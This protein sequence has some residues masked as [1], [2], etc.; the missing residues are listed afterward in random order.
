MA[1][2]GRQALAQSQA[3]YRAE[4]QRLV[5]IW[6]SVS[7]EYRHED[8]MRVRALPQDTMR[9]GVVSVLVDSSLQTLARASATEASAALRRRFG[10]SAMLVGSHLFTLT[11]PRRRDLDSSIV[12]LGEIDT[13][14]RVVATT[15]MRGTDQLVGTSMAQRGSQVLTARLGPQFR[16]WLNGPLPVDTAILADWVGARIDVVTSPYQAAGECYR[17]DVAA[18]K[19][20]LG[21]GDETDPMRSWFTASE[22]RDLVERDGWALR[23]GQETEYTQCV[24]HQIDSACVLLAEQIP[25]RQIQAP[26]G[27]AVRQNL[28]ELAMQ[29]GGPEA[30]DRMVAAADTREAQLTAAAGV[31]IDSL[32]AVWRQHVVNTEAEQT[33]RTPGLALMSLVW[34]AT[35]G[36][37]A[38]GSS[39][40]R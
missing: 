22:R 12:L 40:W 9:V 39:R 32:V 37:L 23:R 38:L 25:I 26:L 20:A 18:C 29:M 17:G 28:T 34:V 8:S 2:P 5:P 19:K 6:R 27:A 11:H 21:V 3:E 4:V 35:C 30:Y 13:T 7:A 16:H 36:G 14:G 24:T 10:A 31:S 33:T 1:A 15:G